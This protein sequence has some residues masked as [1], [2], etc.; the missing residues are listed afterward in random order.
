[1]ARLQ[2]EALSTLSHPQLRTA[3]IDFRFPSTNQARTCYTHYNEYYK[4]VVTMQGPEWCPGVNTLSATRAAYT[5]VSLK[6][7]RTL[8]T[9]PT[10]SAF[11][12]QSA[13]MSGYA[14]ALQ[15]WFHKGLHTL[16]VP[17]LEKWE[18]LRSEDN[19][20]GKY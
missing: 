6:R 12:A 8:A 15:G 19:W 16:F 14:V 7:E 13:L 2:L 9:V 3:P 10:T 18:E 20:F 17:Q 11:T 4:Y 1:M 5:G